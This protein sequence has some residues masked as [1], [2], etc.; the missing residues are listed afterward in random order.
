MSGSTGEPTMRSLAG[1]SLCAQLC[2][3]GAMTEDLD[4]HRLV[5]HPATPPST[6]SAVDV[7]LIAIDDNDL[8]LRF[9]VR[10]AE[11]L[12]LPAPT[13]PERAD[14][15]WQTS[16]FELFLMPEGGQGYLEFNFSP[17][18]RWAAYA[19]DGYR[20]G[21]R[22]LELAIDPHVE[23]ER[24]GS[25]YVLD[26]DLDLSDVAPGAHRMSV[27]AVIEEADGTK[28]YWALAHPPEKPDFHDPACF[29]L[30]LPAAEAA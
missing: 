16:C 3:S 17:S 23:G 4:Y 11:G 21:M 27:S 12:V 25:L 24:A 9:V 13:T 5:P 28:S 29:V 6:I 15:L 14:G 26:A 10:D 7:E 1:L 30:E 8:L 18:G 20:A 22:D 2:L 19:F